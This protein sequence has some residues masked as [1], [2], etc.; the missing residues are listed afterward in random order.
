MTEP[1]CW[2]APLAC[3]P[4]FNRFV[5]AWLDGRAN[6]FLPR[7]EDRSPRL[8]SL[9]QDALDRRAR[10][11]SSIIETNQRWGFS[12]REEVER[13]ARGETY[14][15]VAGQQVGFAGGPLYTL[16]KIATLIRMK[17]DAEAA[18]IPATALFWL[19]TEDH[20]FT[21]VATLSVPAR[22]AHQL[23][24]VRLK[25]TRGF[26]SRMAVGALPIPET[27]VQDFLAL[28]EIPRPSWLREGITFADSFAELL[29]VAVREGIVLV[30]ALLP[31]LRRA[32]APLFE[33]IV[34]RWDEIQADIRRRSLAL[35][36]AGYTPQIL[37]RDGEPYTLF[38]RLDARGNR[39]TF[40]GT[41][42]NPETISTSAL[43]RPLLQDFV[44]RPDVFVGGPAEVAYYAQ[45]AG[46][47]EML[48]VPLPRVALRGHALVAPKRVCR[49]FTRFDIA[50]AEV[51]STADEILADREPAGVGAVSDIARDAHRDLDAAIE[52]IRQ[53]ALPADHAL[54][55]SINRSI[56]HINYHFD[57]LTERSIRGLVRKDRERYA[58][59]REL[60][61]TL[62][63]D[64]HVQDRITGWIAYWLEHGDGLVERLI[65]EI[66]PDSPEFRI[67]SV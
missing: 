45:I 48:G 59:V 32:G 18:G 52:K 14:T 43:T 47:H 27:L 66:A 30:D 26:E 62:Y 44:L 31:E 34:A 9:P 50:P 60:V 3:Y 15:I 19:A 64:R 42:S 12:V 46:M 10:L 28:Y 51:F 24:L 16:A 38:F 63:P 13:W 49:L 65:E 23:D 8:P 54:A 56:G 61:A 5:L 4:G 29:G 33:Q 6:A 7:L 17:R 41:A 36:E 55:R 35:D 57:K 11:S 22:G 21:E 40:D 1:S 2:R 39:Q 58:A 67:V 25:A 53:L 37:A 20:D